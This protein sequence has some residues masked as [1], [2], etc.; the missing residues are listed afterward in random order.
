MY[1]S[2]KIYK[3]QHEDGHFYIG[4]T[5]AELRTRFQGHKRK[6][7]ER[8]SQRVYKHINNEW[9]KVRILLIEEFSCETKQQLLKR[10]DEHIQKELKN[11]LCLNCCRVVLTKEETVAYNRAYNKKKY[12][13]NREYMREYM[14]EYN[15]EYN[16]TH[17]RREYMREYN[18]KRKEQKINESMS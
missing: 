7:I 5:C 8:P 14:R 12:E 9:D 4:S 2:G 16:K 1:S 10:E 17:D 3:L 11:P 6:S 15:K 13:Q 18:K